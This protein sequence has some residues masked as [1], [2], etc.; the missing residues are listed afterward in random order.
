M[1][2][3][4][5][6]LLVLVLGAGNVYAQPLS[7]I[8]IQGDKKIPFY[9]LLEGKMTS[10]YG[11]NYTIIPELRG[12]T[13]NIDVVFQ[14]RIVPARRFVIDVPENGYCG[15]VLDKVDDKYELYDLQTK[16]YLKGSADTTV[17]K[18]YKD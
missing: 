7:Y 16:K 11:K 4:Y 15:F 12:G 18:Y 17:L 14:Q 1:V 6:I 10:R 5:L 2:R 13:Y 9:V 3:L 8:Y